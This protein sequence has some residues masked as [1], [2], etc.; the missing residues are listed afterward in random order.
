VDGRGIS[1]QPQTD[2]GS[3]QTG[4]RG[5][6]ERDTSE[7][8]GLPLDGG[9]IKETP[10]KE[11]VNN[12]KTKPLQELLTET[13]NKSI[14]D[15]TETKIIEHETA[16]ITREREALELEAQLKQNTGFQDYQIQEMIL[17]FLAPAEGKNQSINKNNPITEGQFSQAE[18]EIIP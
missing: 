3:G 11:E 10:G 14:D 4:I 1:G 5:P 15:E 2:E 6:E 16:S 18:E 9:T 13:K 8:N 12:D 17:K 7:T